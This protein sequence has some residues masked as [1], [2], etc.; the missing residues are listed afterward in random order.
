MSDLVLQSFPLGPQ[1]PTADPFL[2]CA[3]HLDGYPRGNGAL[4]P[5]ASLAGREIGS[6]FAG[7]D[8]WNMYHGQSVPG[9][10]QHPHRGFETVTY[11]RTG[12]CDHTDGLGAAARFGEGDTQWLTAGRGIVHAEMFPLI[13]TTEANP[14][15]LFQI[16]LNLP[17]AN[18]M[19]DP[20]FTMHW[21]EQTPVVKVET[22]AG[23]TTRVVVIAGRFGEA[24]PQD[25]PPDSWASHGDADLG[26][27]HAHFEPEAHLE[28]PAARP[29][30][31]RTMYVF[32]GSEV[33]LTAADSAD[34]VSGGTGAI[35]QAEHPT[36]MVAG[37]TGAS[38]LVLQG[39][40]IGEPVARYGPFVMNTEAEIRAAFTDYQNDQ[41]GGWPWP[42]D[43]PTHG[44]EDRFARHPNGLTHHPGAS[45]S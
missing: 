25:P 17:A 37:A 36:T 6:D 34:T 24:V 33:G 31:I 10:P 39:R 4:G 15:E 29:G 16:W 27:W 32:E 45:G 13:K 26:I 5:E 8:G 12:R 42:D 44:T 7:R 19:V 38:V 40:P 11:V 43:A 30:T 41:F 35:V 28:L 20:Y 22:S 14:L 1:W 2:F 21:S 9:F 3:H 18:K 23:A